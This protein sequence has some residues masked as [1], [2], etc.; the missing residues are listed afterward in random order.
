MKGIK[1]MREIE[2]KEKNVQAQIKKIQN[3][4]E[5]KKKSEEETDLQMKLIYKNNNKS[6]KSQVSEKQQVSEYESSVCSS[7]VNKTY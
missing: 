6:N 7:K 4:L 3:K 1:E 2:N 5:K